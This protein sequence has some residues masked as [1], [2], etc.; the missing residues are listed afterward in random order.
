MSPG[1]CCHGE[2]VHDE[3]K[4]DCWLRC[5][6]LSGQHAE[7]ADQSLVLLLAGKE[8]VLICAVINGEEK[9]I[10]TLLEKRTRKQG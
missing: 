10:R 9:D 1:G 5:S 2:R 7:G 4:F 6:V 3:N 8:H